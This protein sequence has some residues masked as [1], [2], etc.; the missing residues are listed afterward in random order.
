M[1]TVTLISRT[2]AIVVALLFAFSTLAQK[3]QAQGD[4][5][6]TGGGSDNNWKTEA[7]WNPTAIAVGDTFVFSVGTRTTSVNDLDADQQHNL[8]FSGTDAFTF[9]GARIKLGNTATGV[10]AGSGASA[11]GSISVTAISTAPHNVGFDL[12]LGADTTFSA[13]TGS[14]INIGGSISGAYGLTKDGAG[15]FSL[16]GSNSYTGLT[17]ISDGTLNIQHANALGTT[18]GA[19]TVSSGGTLSVQGSITTAAEGLTL[20]GTGFSTGGALRSTSGNNTYTGNITLGSN[21][22]INADAG[23]LTLDVASGSSITGTSQNVT[24]G[25]SGNVTVNDSMS[26]GTGG[27]IKDGTGTL[28][29]TTSNTYSGAT[30]ISGG[31]LNI[32]HANALGSTVGSTTVADGATL[33]VQGS[34]NV[35]E[36]L[37]LSGTGV[38]T[39]GALQ[40]VSGSNTISNSITLNAATRINSNAGTLTLDVASGSAITGTNTNVTFGGSGDIVVADAIAVGNGSL[41]KDGT[42]KLTLTGANTYQGATSITGG[43]LQVGNNGSTGSIAST[44]SVNI[45]TGATL[46][47]SRSDALL[48]QADVL[49]SG[50]ITG[51]G[52]LQKTGAG[53]LVLTANNSYTGGTLVSEGTLVINGNQSAA[54]GAITVANGATLTGSGTYGGAPTDTLTINGTLTGTG[55]ISGNTIINGGIHSPGN[56]PGVQTFAGNLTY[57]NGSSVNWELTSNTST[58]RGTNFDGINVGGNLL[59]AGSTLLNLNFSTPGGV[60]W[61][62]AFWGTNQSWL[63]YDLTGGSSTVTNFSNFNIAGSDWADSNGVWLSSIRSGSSFSLAQD[64]NDV[65]IRFDNGSSAIPEPGSLTLMSVIGL[66]GG[67]RLVQRYIRRRKKPEASAC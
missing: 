31:T 26:L 5:N 49:G 35:A 64:G 65:I 8:R 19:T 43:T 46:V 47:V 38:A 50:V 27:V 32:Q 66:F 52:A 53:T 21:A 7:N 11:A 60:N 51:A 36:S 56:S 62:D 58:G 40:N 29:L 2:S 63:L 67:G 15:T 54:T 10:G 3:A 20:N 12:L 30:T 61:A 34:I 14:S 4:R 16:T 57:N 13:V 28:T 22:R 45:G 25:G 41:T 9:S 1:K 37:G 18:A 42:G 24:F 33:S 59:F 6:W 39:G 23:T 55:T 44:S 17:T 48:N